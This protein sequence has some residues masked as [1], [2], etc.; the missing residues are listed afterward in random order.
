MRPEEVICV[1]DGSRDRTA[2][3]IAAYGRSAPLRVRCISQPQRGAASARN[4]GW[5][6]ACGETILFLDADVVLTPGALSVLVAQL[7]ES[8]CGAAVAMYS[9]LSLRPGNLAQFQSC[10]A[11]S[12]FD[13]LD[14]ADSP[15]LGTQCAAI[16]RTTLAQLGG[17]DEGYRFA[18]VEDFELGTR[19]QQRGQQI[20]L[21]REAA[22]FHNHGYTWRVFVRNY[23]VKGRDLSTLLRRSPGRELR[24]GGYSATSNAVAFAVVLA[25]VACAALASRFGIGWLAVTL[26]APLVLAVLWRDLVRIALR[27]H[28]PVR[29]CAFVGLRAVVTVV[30]RRGRVRFAAAEATLVACRSI[31]RALIG[32]VTTSTLSLRVRHRRRPWP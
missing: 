19:V 20:R 23:Y 22:I 13:R 24:A 18:S 17:F 25:A 8:N 2:A 5:R 28:G 27:R 32:W 4:T 11:H 7:R 3:V 14:P 1:D 30:G 9:D 10:L 21:A 6:T 29:A 31:S 15:Y 26:A 16:A 12:I